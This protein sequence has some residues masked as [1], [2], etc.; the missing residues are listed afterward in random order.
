MALNPLNS[1]NMEELA[2]KGLSQTLMHHD[3]FATS[4][5][6]NLQLSAS[7]GYT[8]AITLTGATRKSMKNF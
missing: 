1:S 7:T 6:V 2:L 3:G 4:Q 8:V 5:T